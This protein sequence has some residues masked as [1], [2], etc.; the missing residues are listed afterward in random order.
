MESDPGEEREEEGGLTSLGSIVF[1]GTDETA[2]PA[3]TIGPARSS[4]TVRP[5]SGE[6]CTVPR[7]RDDRRGRGTF[8]FV[9]SKNSVTLICRYPVHLHPPTLSSLFHL[10]RTRTGRRRGRDLPT[11]RLVPN[12]SFSSLPNVSRFS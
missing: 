6:G 12:S 2:H 3:A 1:A 8:G 7:D 9:G 4:H 10:G 5:E 11:R